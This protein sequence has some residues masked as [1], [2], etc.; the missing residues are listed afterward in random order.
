MRVWS[1]EGKAGFV[2]PGP[3]WGCPEHC[4]ERVEAE[5]AGC[6]GLPVSLEL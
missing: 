3:L 6:Q 4:G 1:L 5:Q 2:F